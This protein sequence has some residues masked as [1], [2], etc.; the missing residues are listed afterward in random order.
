MGFLKLRFK[1]QNYKK[2]KAEEGTTSQGAQRKGFCFL[3]CSMSEMEMY[4][5][6]CKG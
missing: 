5:I 4:Y 6:G 3:C 1:E 2:K